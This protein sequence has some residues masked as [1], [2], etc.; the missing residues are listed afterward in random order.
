MHM[1]ISEIK[2]TFVLSSSQMRLQL[3]HFHAVFKMLLTFQELTSIISFRR[4]RWS[5]RNFS[6]NWNIQD[7]QI[8]CYM[9]T[10]NKI[11]GFGI[12]FLPPD[13]GV[14]IL[15]CSRSLLM[16]HLTVHAQLFLV[17]T[18][19]CFCKYVA[20]RLKEQTEGKKLGKCS[21]SNIKNKNKTTNQRK[22]KKKKTR[23]PKNPNIDKSSKDGWVG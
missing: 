12:F 3:L 15:F 21:K 22:R 2:L 23:I 16:V 4:R 9:L 17:F 13:F 5:Q 18:C 19:K 10:L 8:K 14:A 11:W 20:L 6:E 7:N 1:W